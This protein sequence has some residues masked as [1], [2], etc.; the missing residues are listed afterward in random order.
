M[1]SARPRWVILFTPRWLGWHAF[2]VVAAFGM[3]WLGDWQFHRAESG[4][5]LSWAYT[6]EWPVFAG[7]GIVFWA[8]TI[9]DELR[10]PP[11]PGLVPDV[12]L[13]P[14]AGAERGA[15]PAGAG[16]AAEEDDPELAAYNAYLARL[17]AQVKER[18]REHGR[19]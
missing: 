4:N 11:E 18:G 16:A 2:V 12:D 1:A 15:G 10:P 5:A 6:F 9:L 14:G 3:L 8:K 7:F 19:R 17:N 13:P